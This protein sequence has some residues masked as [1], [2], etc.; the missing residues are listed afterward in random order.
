MRFKEVYKFNS[1]ISNPIDLQRHLDLNPSNKSWKL[2]V[3][4]PG[5]GWNSDEGFLLK[6]PNEFK[7]K[8][9]S[10]KDYLKEMNPILENYYEREIKT[11][12]SEKIWE[13]FISFCQTSS[14]LKRKY[15]DF[16]VTITRPDGTGETKLIEGKNK[17]PFE[18]TLKSKQG[19]PNMIIPAIIFKD[20]VRMNMFEHAGISKRCQYVAS[21][22]IDM[23]R[24]IRI[25]GLLEQRER[26]PQRIT[27]FHAVRF[28]L[29]YV[30]RWRELFVYTQALYYKYFKKLP[31]YIV[32]EKILKKTA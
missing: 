24:L 5:S 7:N 16:L 15:G 32:E 6:E 11:V 17:Q 9:V 27:F 23:D 19:L 31:L 28:L 4:M 1:Y 10:I 2:M 30:R 26:F 18:F 13:K 21:N 20:A 25:V 3:M 8:D 29:T 12:V 22:A 14:I